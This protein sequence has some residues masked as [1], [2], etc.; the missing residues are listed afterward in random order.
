MTERPVSPDR[1]L[2]D[3]NEKARALVDRTG[4]PGKE[5]RKYFYYVYIRLAPWFVARLG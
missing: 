3:T 2:C 5:E 1:P 4:C